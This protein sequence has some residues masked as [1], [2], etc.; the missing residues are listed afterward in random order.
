MTKF[1]FLMDYI[2][3][4]AGS[5]FVIGSI[6]ELLLG[7]RWYKS[8]I[9]S[10]TTTTWVL[11]LIYKEWIRRESK[12]ILKLNLGYA[13]E[14]NENI[15]SLSQ[16]AFSSFSVEWVTEFAAKQLIK[17]SLI[18]NNLGI[19]IATTVNFFTD[20]VINSFLGLTRNA[21]DSSPFI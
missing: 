6:I 8:T 19:G 18:L 1:D 4:S 15:Y 16:W 10:W 17:C 14:V 7:W 20:E 9:P 12:N 11:T 13:A 5:F 21:F 2:A 3:L